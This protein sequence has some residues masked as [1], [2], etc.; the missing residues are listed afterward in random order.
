MRHNRQSS[1]LRAS[2]K[3][4]IAPAERIDLVIDFKE[5]TGTEVILNDEFLGVMQLRVRSGSVRHDSVLPA[6]LCEMEKLQE[7]SASKTPVLPA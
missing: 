2:L 7:S 1:G 3:I 5:T 6:T 4:V